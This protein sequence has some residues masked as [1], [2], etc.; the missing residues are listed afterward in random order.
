VIPSIILLTCSPT[1]WTVTSVTSLLTTM[2]STTQLVVAR[3]R[4][5]MILINTTKL[6]AFVLPT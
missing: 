4:A 2:L 5:H 1:W 6:V 3:K